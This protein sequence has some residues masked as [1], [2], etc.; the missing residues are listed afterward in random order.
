MRTVRQTVDELR[1]RLYRPAPPPGAV[2]AYLD[3]VRAAQCDRRR[4]APGPTPPKHRVSALAGLLAAASAALISGALV[5]G[6]SSPQSVRASAGPGA[7]SASGSAADAPDWPPV[8]GVPIGR[9]R[10]DGRAGA[11][12]FSAGGEH[13]VVSV[14]CSGEGT[15]TVRIGPDDPVVLVCDRD[16]VAFALV[17]S[18]T[19][20]H[21]FRLVATTDGP[22]RWSITVGAIDLP[23]A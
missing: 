16:A 20:L 8:T 13:A 5:A 2:A 4:P 10:G 7:S 22:V 9:L 11:G 3:A 15:F 1:V 19:P 6:T 18:R 23:S 14:N 21:R 12:R 17:A